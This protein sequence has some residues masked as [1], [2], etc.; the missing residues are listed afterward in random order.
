MGLSAAALAIGAV[1]A[2]SVPTGG[3]PEAASRIAVKPVVAADATVKVISHN[4]CGNQCKTGTS[5]GIP[6]LEAQINLYAPHVMLLQEVCYNQYVT[7]KAAYGNTYNFAYAKLVT[8]YSNCGTAPND[9]MGQVVAVQKNTLGAATTTVDIPLGGEAYQVNEQGVAF[10][11]RS[12]HAICL[13]TK[14]DVLGAARSVRACSVHLR[15]GGTGLNDPEG[16]TE[17]GK[18]AMVSTLASELDNSIFKDKKLVVV[19][20]DF[21]QAPSWI[22]MSSMYRLSAGTMPGY[23]TFFEADQDTGTFPDSYC[24]SSICRS[25]AVTAGLGTSNTKKYDYIFF[26]EVDGSS[27]LSALPITVPNSDHAFYR[28]QALINTTARTVK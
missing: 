6:E 10:T 24:T 27:S 11:Q 2:A 28:G 1:A 19:G 5:V 16:A 26:S 25:G 17:R 12:F 4:L 22:G 21:N 7:L 23:G 3:T 9:W 14:L 13:D 18:L 8:G 15:T 20:G